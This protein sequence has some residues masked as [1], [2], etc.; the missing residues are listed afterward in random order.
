LTLNILIG[1][2]AW[3]LRS[4]VRKLTRLAAQEG[5]AGAPAPVSSWARSAPSV[6]VAVIAVSLAAFL[7]GFVAFSSLVAQ[8][9]IWL[10]MVGCTTYLLVVLVTDIFDSLVAR[11]RDDLAVE[12][13]NAQQARIRSQ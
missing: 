11:V 2:A 12:H 9:I 1:F 6:L 7:L 10:G 5:E 13:L 3:K 4:S 8:E